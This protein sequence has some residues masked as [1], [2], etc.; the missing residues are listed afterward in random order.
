MSKRRK[1]SDTEAA[2]DAMQVA[3]AEFESD[4]PLSSGAAAGVVQQTVHTPLLTDCSAIPIVIPA[5]SSD[6][7]DYEY[8]EPVQ[9]EVVSA[10]PEEICSI[11]SGWTVHYCS[12]WHE[13]A[14]QSSKHTLFPAQL[15]GDASTPDLYTP[16][17]LGDLAFCRYFLLHNKLHQKKQLITF[18][19]VNYHT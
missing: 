10:L 15:V 12:W 16:M 6:E 14:P 2:A 1:L 3:P 9:P 7:E 4:S 18:F 8:H 11:A 19:A 13:Q 17:S 5:D